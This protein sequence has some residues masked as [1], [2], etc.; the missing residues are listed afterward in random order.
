MLRNFERAEGD[1]HCT[2]KCRCELTRHNPAWNQQKHRQWTWKFQN[3]DKGECGK[4][5]ECENREKSRCWKCDD[6]IEM[7]VTSDAEEL[8]VD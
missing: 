2:Q 1:E 5:H 6:Q 7:V 8:D 3:Q 4:E